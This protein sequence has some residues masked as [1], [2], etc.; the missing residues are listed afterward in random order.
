AAGRLGAVPVARL[1]RLVDVLDLHADVAAHRD[2]APLGIDVGAG[3]ARA[4]LLV[5]VPRLGNQVRQVVHR[6]EGH[7]A[8]DGG[9][10]VPGRDVTD[11]GESQIHQAV[12]QVRGD[13]RDALGAQVD[14]A[15]G[16]ALLL[17]A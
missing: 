1:G 17:L 14:V 15:F 4:D 2:G 7:V 9:R 3:E 5:D 8:G 13:G 16:L 6:I 10:H 12:L 11:A